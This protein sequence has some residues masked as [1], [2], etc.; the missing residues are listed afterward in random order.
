MLLIG[1]I[2]AVTVFGHP[3]TPTDAKKKKSKK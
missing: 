1:V 3:P 2:I